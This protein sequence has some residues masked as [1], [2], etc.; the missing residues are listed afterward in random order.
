MRF[1][2]LLLLASISYAQS[3]AEPAV[4]RVLRLS[5]TGSVQDMNEAVN[6]IRSI[7][8]VPQAAVDTA[9]ENLR[10]SGT[11]S[12]VALAEWLLHKMEPP[13]QDRSTNEFTVPGAADSVVRVFYL[14]NTPTP[15]GVIEIVNMIRAVAEIRNVTACK[16]SKIIALRASNAEVA[17]AAWL[18]EAVDQ[19]ASGGAP[20]GREY[21]RPGDPAPIA[22][23]VYLNPHSTPQEMQELVN[24]IR[25]LAELQRL[26]PMSGPSGSL[27][28]LRAE[29]LTG[30]SESIG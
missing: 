11:A 8:E 17:F 7:S 13:G 1:C 4:T 19:P 12:Q 14:V 18:I 16:A 28:R 10:V 30:A 3:V 5:N 20:T 29:G 23:V 6:A 2:V 21:G 15:Q 24:T 9:A 27:L 22:R 25:S 26:V